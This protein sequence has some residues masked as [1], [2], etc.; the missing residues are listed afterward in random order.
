MLGSAGWVWDASPEWLEFKKR[1]AD[2]QKDLKT[3]LEEEVASRAN[4]IAAYDKRV[5]D[6]EIALKR[7]QGVSL[8]EEEIAVQQQAIEDKKQENMRMLD[9]DPA[10]RKPPRGSYFDY[11]PRISAHTRAAQVR[12]I[13]ATEAKRKAQRAR[14]LRRLR[15]TG[16]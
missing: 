3:R 9:S 1:Y 14:A 8:T 4:E 7:A 10:I 2:G 15:M 11:A 5:L 13:K 12:A 6:A 16:V